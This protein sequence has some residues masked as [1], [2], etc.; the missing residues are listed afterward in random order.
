MMK[1]NEKSAEINNQN[2]AYIADHPYRTL[3]IGGSGS[4]KTK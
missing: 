3:I 1:N 2:W 4:G